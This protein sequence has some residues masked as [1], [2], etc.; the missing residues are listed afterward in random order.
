MMDWSL[1][2]ISFGN[3]NCNYACPCQFE[4]DP[5][6]GDCRG[7]EALRID[8]GNFGSVLLDDLHAVM[9]YAWPGP[10][11][12]GNGEYQI[13]IEE[14]ASA[15][16]REAL[17]TIFSGGET[18]EAK[19]HWW[20]LAHMSSTHHPTLYAP[21]EFDCDIEARTARVVVPGVL[22]ASGRP[23]RSPVDGTAHRVQIVLPNGIE[24]HAA[25]IGSAS[26]RATGEIRLDI[27]DRYGQ[28]N[29]IR[30]TG[31]GLVR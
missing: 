22:E 7:F 1:E 16:Q 4:S 20:V 27:T 11:Y 24:F 25:D 18:E 19:T 23:I 3:C 26:S 13:I 30:H 21:I 29:V 17:E 12:K 8:K 6:E 9:I 14:S 2:G 5:T 31:K 10:I 15:D 28:F